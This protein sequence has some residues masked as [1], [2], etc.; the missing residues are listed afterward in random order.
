LGFKIS[1]F[2]F[3]SLMVC[4]SAFSDPYLDRYFRHVDSYQRNLARAQQ[5]LEALYPGGQIAAVERRF[6]RELTE[7]RKFSRP[8]LEAFRDGD[9]GYPADAFD[10]GIFL[11]NKL[12]A[13]FPGE[14]THFV[15]F[16]KLQKVVY[17]NA[18]YPNLFL[19]ENP[20]LNTM[21]VTLAPGGDLAPN[22]ME[23]MAV[24][25]HGQV[26]AYSH[27][28]S[29]YYFADL[30]DKLN[31]PRTQKTE[32][33]AAELHSRLLSRGLEK[34]IGVK[35][36]DLPGHGSGPN[37]R[38]FPSLESVVDWLAEEFKSVRATLDRSGR[39]HVPLIVVAR[40]FSPNLIWQL[41]KKYP[42][43]I[44]AM[45]AI[46]PTHPDETIGYASSYAGAIREAVG[47]DISNPMLNFTAFEWINNRRTTIQWH[48]SNTPFE[49]PTY[50]QTGFEDGQTP[51]SARDW[52][53]LAAAT[54]PNRYQAFRNR[55]HDTLRLP[56]PL[57]ADSRDAV[58]A[59]RDDV[60][61]SLTAWEGFYEFLNLIP[62]P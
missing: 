10:R 38:H 15:G 46:S 37:L 55:G 58:V 32:S 31:R 47:L 7:I 28:G 49:I 19:S 43:L 27:M 14:A 8:L 9:Q 53:A 4:S 44:D 12:S 2:I 20:G 30:L 39:K 60:A 35:L 11:S 13:V 34:K 21:Q 6:E 56:F 33:F 36:L 54:R 24:G 52:F 3:C 45:V 41:A 51:A 40:S 62:S 23:L 59:H 29:M 26:G 61:T 25:L 16:D 57:R 48:L 5:C 18:P 17:K 1:K 22:D 42:G 50:I